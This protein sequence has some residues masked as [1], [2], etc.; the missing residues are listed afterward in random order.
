MFVSVYEANPPLNV[1]QRFVH[2]LDTSDADYAE[3]LGKYS[4]TCL[5]RS[6]SKDQKWVYKTNY[7]LMQVKSI[8]EWSK[9]SILQYF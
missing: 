9:G 2:L 6:L 1:V 7:C 8:A 4:R 5:K 3:E